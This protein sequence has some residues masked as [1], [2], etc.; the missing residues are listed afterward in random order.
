MRVQWN[1]FLETNR[2]IWAVNIDVVVSLHIHGSE[3][4]TRASGW[5]NW[6]ILYTFWKWVLHLQK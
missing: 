5:G 3:V 4:R 1:P 6:L 2:E